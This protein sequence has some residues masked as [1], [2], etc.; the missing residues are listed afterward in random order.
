LESPKESAKVT[1]FGNDYRIQA[2]ENPEYIEQIAR[3]VDG[4]MRELQGRSTVSSTTKIAILVAM[5]IADDL[6]RERRN[7]N[8]CQS[9]VDLR[10][11]ELT[12]ILEELPSE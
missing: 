11:A 4:K 5:N 10:T 1:I 6:H 12:K 9:E 2:S 3:Y 8:G 7:R